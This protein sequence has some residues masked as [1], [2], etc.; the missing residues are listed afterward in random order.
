MKRVT[1]TSYAWSVHADNLST[2]QKDYHTITSEVTIGTFAVPPACSLIYSQAKTWIE[3][4]VAGKVTLVAADAG[5]FSPDIIL[6]G[7][8]GY[9]TTDGSS[10][11]SAIAEHSVLIPLVVPSAMSIRGVFVAQTG[12]FGRDLY[13]CTYAP[14][15]IRSSLTMNGTVVSN[16]RTGTKW[17]YGWCSGIS[18]FQTRVDSYDRLLAFS[19]PPFTPAASVDYKLSL[20]RE[21]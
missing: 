9:A 14:Y 11:I 6:R 1:G 17:G 20:W 2:W 5:S 7:N 16:L 12:Y 18:G 8:I 10:G 21:Q 4:T 19:P 13:D 3:G 15:D